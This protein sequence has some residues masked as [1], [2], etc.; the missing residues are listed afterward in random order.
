MCSS[1]C[2]C[3]WVFC[4]KSSWER[5]WCHLMTFTS[6]YL[7]GAPLHPFHVYVCWFCVQLSLPVSER[8]LQPCLPKPNAILLQGSRMSLLTTPA[9]SP[10]SK[11]DPLRI[12]SSGG[13]CCLRCLLCN[14]M[15]WAHFCHQ[16]RDKTPSSVCVLC[17]KLK[18]KICCLSNCLSVINPK[19]C[20]CILN[21][22]F[23]GVHL[24]SSNTKIFSETLKQF[25]FH[26]L[27]F[28]RFYPYY[29]KN[30]DIFMSQLN[31]YIQTTRHSLSICPFVEGYKHPVFE[32]KNR[33]GAE[34]DFCI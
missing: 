23:Q 18:Y 10:W 8:K 11:A 32:Y 28:G 27:S 25:S 34:W 20:F 30:T 4:W 29:S 12:N 22:S 7:D 5:R 17:G 24:N 2:Q 3:I 16:D 1:G 15:E 21:N 6:S 14:W 13:I 9:G 31:R 19:P 26:S 33:S